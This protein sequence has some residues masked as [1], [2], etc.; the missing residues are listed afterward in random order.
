[1]TTTSNNRKTQWRRAF[2]PAAILTFA[3]A[4]TLP[5]LKAFKIGVA[6]WPSIHENITANAMLAVMPQADPMFVSN[7]QSGVYNTD[8]S[9]Q[10]TNAFH[11]DN[12]T[13][14]NGGFDNGFAT[15]HGM[16]STAKSEAMTCDANGQCGI[17]PLF[18]NPQ[19][20]S[21]RDLAEDIVKT[22]G[23]LS[24]NG[25]C[26]AELACP[27]GDFASGAASVQVDALPFLLDTDPDPDEVTA[28]TYQVPI[29][30][31]CCNIPVPN[32]AE[33][34]A[35][36]KSNLD[37]LLGPHCRPDWSAWP[38]GS[39]PVC[40]NQLE[41]MAS[42]D[43]DFQ[44]LAGHLRILQYEYQAYYA[45]QHLGHAF[46]TTQDFFAHSNYV[47]LT[48]GRKG[49]QCDPNSYQ[50]AN[51]CDTPLDTT[52][53][54]WTAIPLPTDGAG[55]VM[56]LATFG[57]YF[58]A[59]PVQ[60]TLNSLSSV[61]GDANFNHLQ[62]GFFPCAGDLLGSPGN[63]GIG[64][65]PSDQGFSYCHTATQAINS[66]GSAG[67]NKDE[68]YA[69][70]GQLNHKNF[71]WAAISATRMSVVLFGAFMT[72]LPNSAS[73][74]S[75]S[76]AMQSSQRVGQMASSSQVAGGLHVT[77]N[78]V[79]NG[80]L[81]PPISSAQLQAQ[82]VTPPVQSSNLHTAAGLVRSP[83]NPPQLQLQTPGPPHPPLQVVS[84]VVLRILPPNT[85]PELLQ[86]NPRPHIFVKTFPNRTFRPGERVELRVDAFDA[87]TGAQLPELP[88]VIGNVRGLT[89]KPIP[90]TL[91][92][93]YKQQCSAVGGQP[94]CLNVLAPPT[95]T[96]IAPATNYPGGG[97]NF[98][99]SVVMP[100]LLVGIAG[101]LVLRPGI[102][103]FTV[104][105]VDAQTHQPVPTAEVFMNGKAVAPANRPMTYQLNA[106][107]PLRT[108]G[109]LGIETLP[110]SFGPPLIV[111]A[112]GY[113]DEIVHYVLH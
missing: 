58:N 91:A 50:A 32:F 93:T 92:L 26:L 18:L 70:G 86:P 80:I 102:A 9:H 108:K 63:S 74:I 52:S 111:R 100:K 112:P 59:Q 3:V 20:S 31:N 6:G 46:H 1:M 77:N 27:T 62:T 85:R 96:V 81:R 17:N 8:L 57:N 110:A 29:A 98:G 95:G 65:A 41:D 5:V 106:A 53:G 109:R 22:Y 24:L 90:L 7:V 35:G 40:F 88:V 64:T 34:V 67:I 13:A 99:L 66:S 42:G 2:M 69:P 51:V 82:A 4:G 73:Y 33:T 78:I 76:S 14:T 43:N 30:S 54:P 101:A 105:A 47:E 83:I 36:V 89:S 75:V 55:F 87:K 84:R 23:D 28:Y 107:A 48:A 71:D 12:S 15:L 60:T 56:S 68:E 113:S 104:S 37:S 21:F 94:F 49:P 16:L 72:D 39:S 38:P 61:F 25:G 45:W 79:G 44:L 11:F 103:T 97:G 19:H 10:P